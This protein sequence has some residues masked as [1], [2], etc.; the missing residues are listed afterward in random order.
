[1]AGSERTRELR[2]LQD[3]KAQAWVEEAAN[4]MVGELLSAGRF[5]AFSQG[6]AQEGN[7]EFA[8]RLIRYELGLIADGAYP[9]RVALRIALLQ[10]AHDV[11]KTAA[12]IR[13]LPE[14]AAGLPRSSHTTRVVTGRR[15]V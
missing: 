8:D 5:D 10:A 2:L 1:M 14:S 13:A 7:P 12:S 6:V 9:I 4:R 15:Y 11:L 3:P